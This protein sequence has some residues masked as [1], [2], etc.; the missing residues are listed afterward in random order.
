MKKAL[1]LIGSSPYFPENSRKM[2][3]YPV[4]LDVCNYVTGTHGAVASMIHVLDCPCE[5]LIKSPVY[6]LQGQKTLKKIEKT[7]S[8]NM[9]RQ[10]FFTN[11]KSQQSFSMF[12]LN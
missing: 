8:N 9:K 3:K 2:P 5:K 6:D 10:F 7:I 1:F 11:F 12:P 4:Q